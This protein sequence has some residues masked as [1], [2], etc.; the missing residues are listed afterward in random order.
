V[1][2]MCSSR[3]YMGLGAMSN[4]TAWLVRVS[5]EDPLYRREVF[6]CLLGLSALFLVASL[7]Q[8]LRTP[9]GSGH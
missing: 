3:V 1:G 5:A 6:Y 9:K 7:V 4:F 8:K 2:M